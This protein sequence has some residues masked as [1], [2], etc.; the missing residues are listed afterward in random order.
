[1]NNFSPSDLPPKRALSH[2]HLRHV[3]RATV[4]LAVF[5]FPP[6]LYLYAKATVACWGAPREFGLCNIFSALPWIGIALSS[7]AYLFV[8]WLIHELGY[9]MAC[10]DSAKSNMPPPSRYAW[11]HARPG[12]RSLDQGYHRHVRRVH[13]VASIG[14]AGLAT[15]ISFQYFDGD[16]LANLFVAAIVYGVIGELLNWKRYD[17]QR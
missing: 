7:G 1:M 14:W 17:K 2:R 11:R 16:T 8:I 15:Y 12:Y 3:S 6:A 9:D 4:I 5:G 13:R 10:E